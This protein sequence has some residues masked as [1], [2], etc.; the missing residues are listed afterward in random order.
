MLKTIL[1]VLIIDDKPGDVLLITQELR[2]R[3]YSVMFT[4]VDNSE[5]FAG[6]LAIKKW[7][8]IISDNSMRGFTGVDAW[9]VLKASGRDI[10][11]IIVSDSVDEE[12]VTKLMRLGV[13]DCIMKSNLQ[14]LVPALEREIR[15]SRS[16]REKAHEEKLL[17]DSENRYRSL[18][19][20]S[21]LGILTIDYE[22]KTL[23]V[24]EA[25][26]MILGSPSEKVVK[27]S[28]VLNSPLTKTAGISGFIK[29]CMDKDQSEAEEFS[30]ITSWKKQVYAI[31][32]IIPVK[33]STR[34]VVGAQILI[35]DIAQLR[36]AEAQLL[37]SGKLAALG[38][39]A[40]GIAHELNNPLTVIMGNAQFLGSIKTMDEKSQQIYSE[41]NTASQKCK[42]IISDLL[43][44]S[45]LKETEYVKFAVSKMLDNSV[46]LVPYQSKLNKVQLEYDYGPDVPEIECNVSKIEQVFINL[47][48]NAVQ[49]MPKGGKLKIATSFDKD[50][51]AVKI[52]FSDTGAGLDEC[53]LSKIFT[54][55]FTTKDKGTGLGLSVSQK[56]VELHGGRIKAESRGKG[57]GSTFTVMLPTILPR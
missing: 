37:Q 46:G 17:F 34:K 52:L 49:A 57:L 30:Y 23:D 42:K 38:Q 41:I 45:R 40:A 24:N 10:P 20:D 53:T 2:K 39:M 36:K 35:Q 27:E 31:F 54:P 44:F 12:Q 32:T 15:E 21:P 13:C 56:I 28:N 26:L 9:N 33:D 14:R 6:S 5:D 50:A 22:G 47:I 48:T 29:K 8:V 7:D 3:E 11:F 51:G 18:F 16:R 55:F 25:A 1:Q 19:E 43:E 4:V